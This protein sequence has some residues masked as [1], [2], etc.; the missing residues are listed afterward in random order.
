MA[1]LAQ[2]EE[3]QPQP[4]IGATAGEQQ[5]QPEASTSARSH[6]LLEP[7]V[8]L[9]NCKMISQGAEAVRSRCRAAERVRTQ[10]PPSSP[11]PQRVWEATFC[12]RLCII[13]QR[14]AKKYRHP[15]LDRKLTVS[16]LKQARAPV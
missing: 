3:P 14:F 7:V 11:A 15:S 2:Q 4:P 8:G 9:E 16:R 1:S 5:Q 10:T 6:E 12:G 13:K